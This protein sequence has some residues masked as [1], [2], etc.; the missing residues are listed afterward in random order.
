MSEWNRLW[1][2]HSRLLDRMMDAAQKEVKEHVSVNK[3]TVR[4]RLTVGML[5]SLLCG[6]TVQFKTNDVDLLVTRK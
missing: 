6:G 5:W 3:N 1:D 4:V 2:E